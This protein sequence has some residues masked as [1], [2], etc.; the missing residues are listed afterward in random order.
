MLIPENA[1]TI[2]MNVPFGMAITE[3]IAETGLPTIAHHHDFFWERQRF[4]VNCIPDILTMAFPPVLPSIQHVVINSPADKELS[5][6]TGISAHIIPNIL[7]FHTPAPEIDDYSKDV[8]KD[9]GLKDDDIFIL[10]P[11]RIVARKGIEHSIELISRLKHPKAKL[12]ITHSA[13]DEGMAYQERIVN[14]AN[15]LNV[16][17]II[18]PEIIGE[19]RGTN[20]NGAKIYT[21]WDIYPHADLVTYPSTYEGFGNAFLEAIYFKKPI[22]VNRYSIYEVDIE[23]K[24]FDVIPMDGWVTDRVIDHLKVVLANPDKGRDMA[25]KNYQIAEKFFS[26]GVLES[27]LRSILMNFQG[28]T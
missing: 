19:N 4:L 7:D 6:R 13:G 5:F 21:L 9:L 16:P 1:L 14:Y 28:L 26:Y 25:E 10:Q 27:N 12:V 18:K 8:R 15:M 17:L 22:V 24:G 2:P 23:P 20:E 3:L 11:T